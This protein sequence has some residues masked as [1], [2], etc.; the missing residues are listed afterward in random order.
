MC[1]CDIFSTGAFSA[2]A[3][4]VGGFTFLEVPV[5]PA[6]AELSLAVAVVGCGPAGLLFEV[7]VGEDMTSDIFALLVSATNT[8]WGFFCTELW[9]VIIM[10]PKIITI[11]G[12]VNTTHTAV[13]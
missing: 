2:F 5:S 13:R 1:P 8:Y 7:A 10:K 9:R 3:L 6:W 4:L 12:N 11:T